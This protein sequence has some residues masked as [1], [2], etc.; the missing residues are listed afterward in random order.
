MRHCA[1][2]TIINS[3]QR[4]RSA[5]FPTRPDRLGIATRHHVTYRS[6]ICYHYSWDMLI[7]VSARL[8]W[9]DIKARL[10]ASLSSP[11]HRYNIATS[12]RARRLIVIYVPTRPVRSGPARHLFAR[13]LAGQRLHIHFQRHRKSTMRGFLSHGFVT[14]RF[15]GALRKKPTKRFSPQKIIN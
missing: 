3:D 15:G 10:V 7:K 4:W 2:P 12:H 14:V 1:P 8:W 11:Q 9:H 13:S 5:H 6:V